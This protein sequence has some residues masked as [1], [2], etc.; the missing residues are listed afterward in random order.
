MT[1]TRKTIALISLMAIM[2][3]G[4][5]DAAD[6]LQQQSPISGKSAVPSESMRPEF[7]R[8]IPAKYQPVSGGFQVVG[9]GRM[10][11]RALYGSHVRDD[12]QHRKLMAEQ[13]WPLE[14]LPLRPFDQPALKNGANNK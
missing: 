13:H 3:E 8:A 12:L 7:A 14:L 1:K 4:R 11:N 5:L 9:S 2:F 6:T 10:F